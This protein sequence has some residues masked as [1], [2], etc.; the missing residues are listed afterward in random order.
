VAIGRELKDHAIS[1]AVSIGVGVASFI[2]VQRLG[3]GA[4]E[5]IGL[6]VASGII[7]H[8]IFDRIAYQR[9]LER[10]KDEII[11]TL[12]PGRTFADGFIIFER[13]EDAIQYVVPRLAHSLSVWNTRIGDAQSVRSMR[14]KSSRFSE[15]DHLILKAMMKGADLRLVID[16]KRRAEIDS[17]VKSCRKQSGKASF[18]SLAVCEVDFEFLPIMQMLII[19]DSDRRSEALVGWSI[20]LESRFHSK[21]L[22]FRDPTIVQFFRD[23]FERYVSVATVE[24]L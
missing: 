24:R 17:F 4:P 14:V 6:A 3:N 13:E 1:A 23:L 19:E 22:L 18:G 8:L 12:N 20:G 21:V 9:Q 5:A 2:L 16:K 15:Y 7:T 10:A 11:S